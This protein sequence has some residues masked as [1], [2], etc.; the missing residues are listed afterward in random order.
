L[1]D[2]AGRQWGAAMST[3]VPLDEFLDS[4]SSGFTATLEPVAEKPAE[5]KVTPFRDARGCGC[6]M[7]FNLAKDLVRS[8]TPTGRYHFCCGK[9]LEV[10]VV[11]FAENA[12]VPVAELMRRIEEP[13]EAMPAAPQYLSRAGYPSSASPAPRSAAFARPGW[14]SQLV[15]RWPI[16]WTPCEIDCIEVC[17]RF[18]GPTGWDC[19]EWETRCAINC[20]GVAAALGQRYF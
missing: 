17:T 4:Q 18:C 13:A 2:A 16:P 3:P 10:A 19:C 12:S 20:N 5:V 14:P 9:R 11:E 6:A 8:V 15:G 1:A 7:S